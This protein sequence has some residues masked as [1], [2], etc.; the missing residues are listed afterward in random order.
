MQQNKMVRFVA[1]MLAAAIALAAA[2]AVAVAT[3]AFAADKSIT[4][5]FT[6]SQTGPLNV[7]SKGQTRG[8]DFW[9]DEVNAKGGI[10]VGNEH[11]KVNFVSYDDQS[12]GGRVQQLYTRLI[13]HDKAQ[14]LFS[15]YS[16][17]MTAPATVVS[18]EYN[19]IMLDSGGAEEKPFEQGNKYL[20]MVITSAGHYLS[21]AIDALKQKD[22]HAK[23]A[24]VYS[25]DPFSKAVTTA[26]IKQAKET[27]LDVVM[28]SSYAPSTTDFGP[29]VTKMIS[30]GAEAF[31]GGGHYADGA[32]LAR[33]MYEQRASMKFVSILVAPSDNKFGELGAAAQGV[34]FPSQWEPQVKYKP[35]VGPTGAEF[36]KAFEAKYHEVP[37][38]HAASGYT[39]GLILQY[40]LEQ[41]NS[42]D[43]EKVAAAL[44]ATDVTTFFGHIKFATDPAHHGLQVG[45]TMV[46]G[47]WQKVNGKPVKQVV[48]PTDAASAKMLYPIYATH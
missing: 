3:P 36:V 42:L 29:I 15:P 48:W 19:R 13:N 44:N 22:P 11:Y 24:I 26:A 17:G 6:D 25:D 12:V 20:F 37:D 2:A 31:L 38:Y 28:E 34:T 47:Q 10:K 45:H 21:G 39:D 4:I 35:Q 40:A 14:F 9:R 43:T 30:S 5:G 8:Y 41:A 32:T 46:L 33:Q 23:V 16:S 7:D 18:E 1:P 27:G